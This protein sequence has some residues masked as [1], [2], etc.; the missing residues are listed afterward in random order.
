MRM[1][2]ITLEISRY[3]RNCEKQGD[4]DQGGGHD[5]DWRSGI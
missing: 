5:R 4:S 2:K 3:N 1:E